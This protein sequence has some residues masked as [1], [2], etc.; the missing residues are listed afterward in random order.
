MRGLK[1]KVSEGSK[2]SMSISNSIPPGSI[3]ISLPLPE[4]PK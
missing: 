2:A 3:N 1:F 4:R